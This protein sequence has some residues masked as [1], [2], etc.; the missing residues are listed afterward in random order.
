MLRQLF[1]SSSVFERFQNK[2]KSEYL[3]SKFLEEN[4]KLNVPVS[5][6]AG[7]SDASHGETAAN[8]SMETF[9]ESGG[10]NN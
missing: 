9:L 4:M 7:N 8:T 3:F 6:K 2:F 1:G 5:C 10:I